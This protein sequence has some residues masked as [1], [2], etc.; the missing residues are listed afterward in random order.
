MRRATMQ[1]QRGAAL[2]VGL[3]MLVLIT[4]M[5]LTALRLGTSS[6]RAVGNTQFRSEAIAA[7][8]RAIDLV[9]SSDFTTTPAAQQIDVDID[10]N[11]TVD[12]RV[13]IAVPQCI[14][15]TQA[16]GTDPSS[17]A[18]PAAMTVASTWNT[19]WDV[20]A[21]VNGNQ[22]IGGAAV[23]VRSGVRVLLSEAQRNAVCP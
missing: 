16:F 21:T 1:D 12:Y 8:N 17:V 3:I 2:A 19:V 23:R 18:L 15:A 10:N 13:N 20:D 7:A 9:I 4:L 14:M 5:L 11:G 6:F 22:N